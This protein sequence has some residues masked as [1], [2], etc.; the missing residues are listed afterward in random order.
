MKILL[1][2]EDYFPVIGGAE[3]CVFNLKQEL[4]KLGHEVTIFT[5]TTEKTHDEN[6]IVRVQWRFMPSGLWKNFRTLWRLIG[7]HDIVH[8]QYSFRLACIAA[9]IAR[10][11]HKPML[12]TQQGR[13]IVPEANPTLLGSI[14]M[15]ICQH[16][17][18]RGAHHITST[19]DEITDLTAAFVSRS[20]I[21]LLSNGYDATLFTPDPTLPIPSEFAK[22]DPHVKK[23]L[24]VRR[25]VPKNGIHILVQALALVQKE[26]DDFHF[27][28][29]GEGRAREFIESLVKEFQLERHITFL[30]KR[31]NDTLLP[32]YQHA[33]LILIP[34]SAEARSIACI[35][36]MGMGKPIIASRVG[37][38]I[39]LIRPDNKYGQLV[40]IYETEACTY[41]PPDRMSQEELQ[42]LAE[43]IITFLKDP[44]EL[45]ARGKAARE[46]VS[47][48]YS[49]KAITA[50]Y[51]SF[52]TSLTD[53]AR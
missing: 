33:D 20:K 47:D 25:L 51:L 42:P 27:F 13:G 19:S 14:F 15:K 44:S 11:R 16:I 18:M 34:S 1:T 32:Y 29:V 10:I 24:S 2:C 12:L 8:S 40:S 28:S 39:D 5:N 22:L 37:G 35:E 43:A 52:Y 48:Q 3:I 21:T 36:A 31:T 23:F 45:Q 46:F 26:R 38:L 4:T 41:D 50:Q 7:S 53:A 49:W 17:S 6:N 30:G 9:I